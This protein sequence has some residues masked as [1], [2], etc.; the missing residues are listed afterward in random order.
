MRA[1]THYPGRRAAERRFPHRVDVPVP[2]GGLGRRLTEMLEWCRE[3]VAA[4]AWDHHGRSERRK[5]EAPA[6]FARFYFLTEADAEA[7]RREFA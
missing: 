2:G 4:G 3:N 6:D 1:R 7:F 5:G